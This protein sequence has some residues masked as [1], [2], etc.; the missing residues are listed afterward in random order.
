MALSARYMR[1][2]IFVFLLAITPLPGR[3][4]IFYAPWNSGVSW[5][6]TQGNNGS[7]SHNTGNLRYA[8]DFSRSGADGDPVRAAAPGTVVLK[9]DSYTGSTYPDGPVVFGNYI[10]INHG[11]GTYTRY[12]HLKYG[13]LGGVWVGK[14]V[15]QGEQIAEC[16]MT[17]YASGPHIHFQVQN[18][19]TGPSVPASF[20]DIGLPVTGGWYTSQ[21][22]ACTAP[23]VPNL[24]QPNEWQ[25]FSLGS[26][27]NLHADNTSGT[28][29]QTTCF[30]LDDWIA[31]GY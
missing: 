29:P 16:G 14:Q 18:S 26:N 5:Q 3:A 17:G 11:D 23:G 7:F 28:T 12:A 9:E 15:G 30:W 27:P 4:T 31:V 22:N 1:I 8:W 20:Q 13:S 19:S 10:V 6:C 21:N 2:S 25:S 24:T